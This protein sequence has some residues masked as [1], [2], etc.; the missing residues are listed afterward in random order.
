MAQDI[1]SLIDKINRE[2]LQAAQEKARQ[3]EDEAGKKAED[4]V[5]RAQKEA[6]AILSKAEKEAARTEENTLIVLKQASRD[7]LL[8]FKNEINLILKKVAALQ[9]KEAL[10]PQ[11]MAEIIIAIIKDSLRPENGGIVISLNKESARELEEVLFSRLN[12]EIKKGITIR[13]SEDTLAG[14]LISFDE[15]KSHYDFSPEGLAE[16][17]SLY[18]KPKLGELFS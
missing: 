2:G 8:N 4:I 1:Q 15:G 9:I 5:S 13:P 7:L 18:L 3:I 17:I 14:F 12:E 6:E 10:T 11:M 16:Y